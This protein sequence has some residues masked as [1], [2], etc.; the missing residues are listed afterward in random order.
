MGRLV[1]SNRKYLYITSGTG[2]SPNI[3]GLRF[4]DSGLIYN[5]KKSFYSEDGQYAIWYNTIGVEAW[6]IGPIANIGTF[7]TNSW[8]KIGATDITTGSYPATFVSTTGTV[9]ISEYKNNISIK[10]QNLGGG[11]L[12]AKP[13]ILKLWLKSDAGV[14]LDGSNVIGWTDQSGNSRNFTKS[15]ANTGF[16]TFSDGAVLFTATNT[17]D[18]PNAS[19]LALPSARLNFTTPYTLFT[20]V[21]AGANNSAIFSK[22]N[23]DSKRRKYQIAVNGGS[24]YA[25]ESINEEDNYITYDTGTGDDVNIKRLIVSQFT[26]NTDGII[27]YNGAEV[28][29]GDG[30]GP[31]DEYGY[32]LDE[33]NSASVFIGAA[34]F[35]EGSGYNA[36][37]S[38][39]MYVYEIL[40]YNQAL[41]TIEIQQIEAYLNNKYSIY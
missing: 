29:V 7:T 24:I 1:I 9:T 18:D 16:P 11:R 35:S 6:Y 5:G 23:D 25:F 41:S 33:T 40:F 39:E 20:V 13:N 4:Y 34:A 27:R 3:N 10:K 21:R 15:I 22:S 17:Y 30:N 37:A 26:S 19:V 31:N 38:T 12:T 36:E 2:L 32:G 14:I 28:A 8:T